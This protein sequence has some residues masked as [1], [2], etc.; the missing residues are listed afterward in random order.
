VRAAGFFYIFDKKQFMKKL[1]PLLLLTLIS[2]N[3]KPVMFNIKPKK[4]GITVP[5]CKTIINNNHTFTICQTG[6]TNISIL[7]DKDTIYKHTEWT[8]GFDIKDLNEDG[9]ND[10]IFNYMSNNVVEEIYLFDKAENNFKLVEH[11]DSY[12]ESIKL[13]GAEYYYTYNRRGCSDLNWDSDL[14]F[15]KDFKIHKI[16][17]ITGVGCPQQEDYEDIIKNGI[18]IYRFEKDSIKNLLQYIPRESGFY[19]DKWD[20]IEEYWTKNYKLFE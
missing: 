13:K 1:I 11:S 14:Y 17:N 20:F 2:C 7:R 15:I 4:E 9:Y 10:I 18:Y 6:D 16:G 3:D 12:P 5:F 8:N 19:N